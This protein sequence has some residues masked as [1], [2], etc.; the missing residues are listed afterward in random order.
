M[1][2]ASVTF[3]PRPYPGLQLLLVGSAQQVADKV[4]AYLDADLDHF[5]LDFS[6]H[7]ID[8]NIEQLDAFVEEVVPL[9]R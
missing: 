8:Y 5:I 2:F 1:I 6:R 4:Q 3:R 7:G 9:L